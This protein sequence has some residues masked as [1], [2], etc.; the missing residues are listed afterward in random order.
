MY[1]TGA[2]PFDNAVPDGTPAP[3]SPLSRTTAAYSAVLD[4][5][6]APVTFLGLTPGF[7]GLVQ[8]NIQVPRVSSGDHSL[9]ITVGGVASNS[10]LV[11]VK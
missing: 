7:I 6:N 8:A 10:A 11:S 2:G 9:V 5:T 1:L 3:S 4:W